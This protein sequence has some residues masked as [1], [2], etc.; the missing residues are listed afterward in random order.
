MQIQSLAIPGP[1]FIQPRRLGDERGWFS[2]V[3]RK[4]LLAEAGIHDEFVQDNQ[5]YSLQSGTIRGLHFQLEPFAQAKIVH[6]LQGAILD[7]VVDLRRSSPHFLK[8]VAVRLDAQTGTQI[9]VPVGFGH[10]FCTLSE[11][12]TISYKVSAPYH[13][14]SDRGVRWNDPA[15]AIEWPVEEAKA[16]LS[17]KDR[18]APLA[19][20]C[21]C[22]F[23]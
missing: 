19:L 16:T 8:H 20:A 17:T 21:G 18:E 12:T 23:S 13:A 15:L 1:L 3:Y 9:Y 2:E 10:G 11:M 22:L 4:D 5:S 14:A 7:V 6:V